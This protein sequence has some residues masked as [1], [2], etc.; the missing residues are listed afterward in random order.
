MATTVS[1]LDLPF[2]EGGGDAA[3]E[4]EVNELGAAGSAA[5]G[6][7]DGAPLD[8]SGKDA[9]TARTDKRKSKRMLIAC[10]LGVL[11]LLFVA[12]GAVF[13]VKA[14]VQKKEP[15]VKVGAADTQ[16]TG[17]G[18]GGQGGT[19]GGADKYQMALELLSKK[20]SQ[21]EGGTGAGA[22]VSGGAGGAE[23][24]GVTGEQTGGEGGTRLG[25]IGG[26]RSETVGGGVQTQRQEGQPSGG[27]QG[28][29]QPVTVAPAGV[30][31]QVATA[32]G[33]SGYSAAPARSVQHTARAEQGNVEGGGV[34]TGTGGGGGTSNA[35][36]TPTGPSL[37]AFGAMLPVRS[38]GAIYTLRSSGGVVRF[39]VA[40]DKRGNGWFIPKGTEIIGVV[41]GSDG[42][43]AFITM[44]GF[45]DPATGKF[46]KLGGDMLGGDGASGIRGQKKRVSGGW[47]RFLGGLRQVGVGALGTLAGGIGRGPIIISD[48]Y[49]GGGG[50]ISS[51]ISGVLGSRDNDSFVMLKAGVTGYA[52]VTQMP[53]EIEG[54]GQLASLPRDALKSISDPSARRAATGLSE[55][56][57]ADLLMSGDAA[58]IRQALPR[59]TGEM[60][61]V[62]EGFLADAG[63]R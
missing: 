11:L 30:V 61:R 37:P 63:V 50:N 53:D 35:L 18:V 60:R 27:V 41:R 25:E 62:A 9:S 33:L 14:M 46:V 40:Y 21:A 2:R 6:A 36:T 10:L 19:D 22:V 17:G 42:D 24:E 49:R 32:A 16:A 57:L 1:G 8:P 44:T 48:V 7:A 47:S 29:G 58:K 45:I 59:M 34:A 5:L 26:V 55:D 31:G 20:G 4:A 28:G 38:L 3:R 56:E 54:L 51:E 12:V 13:V 15:T 23:E 43:R 39:E 52:Y